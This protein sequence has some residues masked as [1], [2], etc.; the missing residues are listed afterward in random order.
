MS[1]FN[2]IIGYGLVAMMF[3]TIATM[4]V[5]LGVLPAID[6]AREIIREFR[7]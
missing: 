5:C 6:I 4:A 1:L 2:T 3:L 7:G